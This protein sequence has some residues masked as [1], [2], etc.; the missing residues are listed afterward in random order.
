MN[1]TTISWMLWSY[2]GIYVLF[3]IPIDILRLI[4]K[5]EAEYPNPDFKNNIQAVLF[6]LPSFIFWIYIVVA[7]ILLLHYG[8]SLYGN[9]V[10]IILSPSL[11]LIPQ[12]SDY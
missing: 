2:L 7:P 8:F 11:S 1:F 4:R 9:F 12:I 3:H 10:Y 5:K 6:I